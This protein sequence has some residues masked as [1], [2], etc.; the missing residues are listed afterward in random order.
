MGE[1]G[2]GFTTSA[3]I[4]KDQPSRQMGNSESPSLYLLFPKY[5][6]LE[7]QSSVFGGGITLSGMFLRVPRTK[8]EL[9]GVELNGEGTSLPLQEGP[10][11]TGRGGKWK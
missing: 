5:P 7:N 4:L 8:A 3:S 9:E 11:G 10:G 1:M 6:K 2:R